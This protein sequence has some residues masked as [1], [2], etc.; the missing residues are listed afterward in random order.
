VAEELGSD[1]SGVNDLD[2]NLTVVAGRRGLAEAVARRLGTMRGSLVGDPDY[3]TDLRLFLNAPAQGARVAAA[4]EAEALKEERLENAQAIVTFLPQSNT[5]N[6]DLVLTDADGPFDLT[7]A[8]SA[9]SVE[10]L[11]TV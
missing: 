9:V 3:G 6:V 10:L 11:T 1:I 7:L 2:P 4:V 5:I 8:V